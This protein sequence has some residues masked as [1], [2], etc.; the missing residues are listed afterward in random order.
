MSARRA[1]KQW[2]W[3]SRRGAERNSS[4]SPH[5]CEGCVSKRER[6][7]SMMSHGA[8]PSSAP[9]SASNSGACR[10][11][12]GTSAAAAA[13]GVGVAASAGASAAGLFTASATMA[14]MGCRCVSLL[15]ANLARSSAVCRWMHR[16]GMRSSGRRTQTSCLWKAPPGW[17]TM[18]SPATESSRSNHVCHSPP[19]YASTSTCWYPLPLLFEHG[20]SLRTGLSVCA[21][22]MLKPPPETKP[23]P[24]AKATS[25]PPRT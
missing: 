10:P 19:P 20:L 6:S 5:T 9:S 24:I 11:S 12:R 17:R 23:A 14:R 7:K 18:T 3:L 21:P 15:T 8:Q 4:E 22:M 2:T 16:L 13:P 1:V 25:V